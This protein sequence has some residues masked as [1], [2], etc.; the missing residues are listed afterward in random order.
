MWQS[1]C[2]EQATN[3]LLVLRMMLLR[4]MLKELDAFLAQGNRN[5]HRILL[6][7]KLFRSWQ[8]S[9]HDLYRISDSV[10]AISCSSLSQSSERG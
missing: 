9:R 2:V 1:I 5:F 3:H 7:G 4:L 6:E 10:L 8:E